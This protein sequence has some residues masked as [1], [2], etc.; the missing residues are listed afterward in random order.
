MSR[1]K[2][3]L[4]ASP[5]LKCRTQARVGRKSAAPSASPGSRAYSQCRIIVAIGLQVGHSLHCEPAA[6]SVGFASDP[7]RRVAGCCSAGP[8]QR[9]V[10]HR[11]LGRAS[12]PHALRVDPCS[13]QGA[14]YCRKVTRISRAVGGGRRCA[15]PPYACCAVSQPRR[16]RTVPGGTAL[17][18]RGLTGRLSALPP[19]D[20]SEA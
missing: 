3:H 7:N 17:E 10:P 20:H 19:L 16:K 5:E 1:S 6:P 15:F 9:A 11:R 2:A 13:S 4:T 18:E 12:R 14:R 8:R